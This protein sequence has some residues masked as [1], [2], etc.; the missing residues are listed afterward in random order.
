MAG[1]P[2]PPLESDVVAEGYPVIQLFVDRARR[3]RYDYE[4]APVDAPLAARLCGL[5]AG[6][7]LALELAVALA[8]E[9]LWPSCWR[10]STRSLDV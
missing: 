1:L 4:P 9:R 10:R 2:Y 5:L 8:A 3:R 6:Y 7:P